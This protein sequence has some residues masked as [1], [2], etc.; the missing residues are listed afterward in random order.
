M[1]E[2]LANGYSSESY[3]L[4]ESFPMNINVIGFR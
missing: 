2:T 3:I 1:T 4:D